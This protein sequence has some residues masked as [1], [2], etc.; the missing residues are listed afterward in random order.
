MSYYCESICHHLGEYFEIDIQEANR[1]MLLN[2]YRFLT[3][4]HQY[5]RSKVEAIHR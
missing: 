4:G 2:F 5:G 1:P 3:F